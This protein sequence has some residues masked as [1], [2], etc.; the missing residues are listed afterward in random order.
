M[1]HANKQTQTHKITKLFKEGGRGGTDNNMEKH[2]Q[3]KLY[4][5]LSL[6]LAAQS[7]EFAGVAII[8]TG[9]ET[10]RDKDREG[11]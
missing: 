11:V 8:Y 9:G 5:P 3:T 1:Q 2:Q 4:N 7:N 6:A 10:E